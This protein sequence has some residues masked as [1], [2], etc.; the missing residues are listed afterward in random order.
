MDT[1]GTFD[2]ENSVEDCSVVFA[3]S[4]LI[5]SVQI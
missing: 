2:H 5:S 3:L 1:Q 4:T